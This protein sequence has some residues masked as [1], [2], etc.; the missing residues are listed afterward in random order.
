[1]IPA[2][3]LLV[4]LSCTVFGLSAS[5]G[6]RDS[7]LI[8]EQL[9]RMAGRMQSLVCLRALPLH[10]VWQTLSAEFPSLFP[11]EYVREPG[12]LE[13]GIRFSLP[14][15]PAADDVFAELT[16]AL[17]AGEEPEKVF[18]YA[19]SRLEELRCRAKERQEKYARLYPALGFSAGCFLALLLV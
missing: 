1:M 17:S 13:D 2:G 12:S 16:E 11:A 9:L 4:L 3:A 7:V 15:L 8:W 10:E 5:K 6:L 14:A 18:S 19:C